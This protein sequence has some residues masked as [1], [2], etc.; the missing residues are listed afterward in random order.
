LY[1]RDRGAVAVVSLSGWIDRVALRRLLA[2]LDDL[3]ARGVV[4]LLL[5][6][7]RLRHI[8]Y[9][10]ITLLIEALKGFAADHGATV[11][12]GLSR[13]LRDLFRLAGS[14]APLSFAPSAAEL[15]SSAAELEPG[16][17]WAS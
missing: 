8:D 14:R 15:L 3:S 4:R 6:G 13:H 11:V 9:P 16:R 10:L 1:E 12:C 5:D 7:S 17:E 2:T